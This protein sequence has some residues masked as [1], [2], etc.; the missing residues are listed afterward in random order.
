MASL[1]R[2]L[3]ATT[4]LCFAC[5]SAPGPETPGYAD[6]VAACAQMRDDVA[7]GYL[8]ARKRQLRDAASEAAANP[9]DDWAGFVGVNAPGFER[10]AEGA[11]Q[12]AARQDR[13]WTALDELFQ[14]AYASN[15]E[16]AFS[17]AVAACDDLRL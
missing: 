12:D 7:R 5:S 11:A 16:A 17:R 6:A 15:A 13:T 1:L 10:R 4:V 8:D 14:I 2:P 3:I 9:D